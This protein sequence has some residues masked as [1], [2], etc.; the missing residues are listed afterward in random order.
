MRNQEVFKVQ[1]L[2]YPVAGDFVFR[3]KSG[4]ILS[5]APKIHYEK[6]MGEENTI[7]VKANYIENGEPE[8]RISKIV[9][10]RNW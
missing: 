10:R 4:S 1:R 5:M 7:F 3:N 9:E 2:A 8:L 6:L